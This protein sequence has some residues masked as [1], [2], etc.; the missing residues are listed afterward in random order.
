MQ[1]IYITL[2]IISQ[3]SVFFLTHRILHFAI[4]FSILITKNVQSNLCIFIK[5]SYDPYLDNPWPTETFTFSFS[6]TRIV[7]LL[8]TSLN[9]QSIIP[10]AEAVLTSSFLR[11]LYN[12]ILT[13][14]SSFSHLGHLC[15]YLYILFIT[16][17]SCV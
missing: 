16:C 11:N 13:F 8:F 15:C 1:I 2:Y 6:I 9:S 12:V 5:E 10:C 17:S 14:S 4:Q 3:M 7:I